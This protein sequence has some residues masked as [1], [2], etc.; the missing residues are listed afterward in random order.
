MGNISSYDHT[1]L[2][3]VTA[4]VMLS[5]SAIGIVIA[6]MLYSSPADAFD[7]IDYVCMQQCMEAGSHYSY[8]QK[9]CSY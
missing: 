8:C 5:L 1:Y 2:L 7:R 6:L 3:K 4:A 9:A